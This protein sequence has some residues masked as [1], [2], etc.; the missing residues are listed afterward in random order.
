MTRAAVAKSRRKWFLIED[1]KPQ[2]TAGFR[3]AWAARRDAL[4]RIESPQAETTACGI[5][6]RPNFSLFT[7]HW[8]KK[9]PPRCKSCVRAHARSARQEKQKER[10]SA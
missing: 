6:L 3:L 10:E 4:H 9:Q 7:Q 8:P 2:E 1:Y 5:A